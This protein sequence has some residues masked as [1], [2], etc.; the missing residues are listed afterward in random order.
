MVNKMLRDNPLSLMERGKDTGFFL[1]IAIFVKIFQN[2]IPC[3]SYKT[4]SS[5]KA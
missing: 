2:F 3:P 5:Q 4:A 1:F